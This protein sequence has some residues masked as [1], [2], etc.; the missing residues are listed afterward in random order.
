MVSDE[1]AWV[2]DNNQFEAAGLKPGNSHAMKVIGDDVATRRME[3]SGYEE[4]LGHGENFPARACRE[5]PSDSGRLFVAGF[6]QGAK[7]G[8]RL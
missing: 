5:H 2:D 6:A 8:F 3:W 7:A 1:L 4:K